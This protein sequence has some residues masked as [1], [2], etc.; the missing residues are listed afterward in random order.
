M[1][2]GAI[3]GVFSSGS[4]TTLS[5]AY[6]WTELHQTRFPRLLQA[7]L[8]ESSVGNRKTPLLAD[9]H[10]FGGFFADY[11]NFAPWS[12]FWRFLCRLQD[13]AVLRLPLAQIAPNSVS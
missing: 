3:F 1:L 5:C 9:L 10:G 12:N 7:I 8:P 11:P 4:K 2:P 13:D 6:L